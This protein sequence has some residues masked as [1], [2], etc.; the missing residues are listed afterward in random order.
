MGVS[1]T[2]SRSLKGVLARLLGASC[3]PLEFRPV[4][5]NA[6]P[7]AALLHAPAALFE[8]WYGDSSVRS[9]PKS[10]TVFYY[11]GYVCF[12]NAQRREIG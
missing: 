4:V 8:P 2:S 9:E 3:R 10:I 7:P 1:R 11:T 12:T 6:S 5:R